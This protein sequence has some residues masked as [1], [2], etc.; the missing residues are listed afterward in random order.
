MKYVL[1][2]VFVAVI[3][4]AG[5]CDKRTDN[6]F[7][8]CVDGVSRTDSALDRI[9]GTRSTYTSEDAKAYCRSCPEC[10]SSLGKAA[11]EAEGR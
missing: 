5:T 8:S 9:T 4:F 3:G 7:A 1:T 11:D 6:E 2:F 10:G